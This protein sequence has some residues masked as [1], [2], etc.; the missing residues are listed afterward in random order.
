MRDEYEFIPAALAAGLIAD[1]L[2]ERLRSS[3][4]RPRA[5]RA[6]AFLTPVALYGMF[7]LA[8]LLTRGI[9]WSIHL[10]PGSIVIAGVVGWLLSYLLV[11]PPLPSE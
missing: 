7:F 2:A 10:W 6:F 4:V 9:G 5:L 11:P 8:L 3:A 1:L